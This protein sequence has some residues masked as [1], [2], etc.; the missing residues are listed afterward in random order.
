[1]VPGSASVP[2]SPLVRALGTMLTLLSFRE[3]NAIGGDSTQSCQ[4]QP[5]ILSQHSGGLGGCCLPLLTSLLDCV[6]VR[7]AWG[8]LLI[9]RLYLIV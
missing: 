2:S 9:P 7:A 1:M 4:A 3:C 6:H 5:V 8:L